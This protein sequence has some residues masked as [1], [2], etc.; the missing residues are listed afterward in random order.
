MAKQNNGLLTRRE[1]LRRMLVASGGVAGLPLMSTLGACSADIARE[2]SPHAELIAEISELIIPETDT[3]GAKSAGV[4]EYVQAVVGTFYTKAARDEF[5]QNLA[6]FDEMA[7]SR[8]QESFL[9]A[10]KDVRQ[11][12]LGELDADDRQDGRRKIW[13]ELRSMVIFGYYTSEAAADELLYDPIPGR[14]D[15]SADFN[16]IGRAWLIRGI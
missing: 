7:H 16:E 5:I 12:I 10:P 14:Y 8:N 4:P 3:A 9:S 11:R 13:R 6:L 1:T 2:F 15:G